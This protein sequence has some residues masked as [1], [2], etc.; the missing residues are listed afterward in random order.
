MFAYYYLGNISCLKIFPNTLKL[1]RIFHKA[2][3]FCILCTFVSA[4]HPKMMAYARRASR[5]RY[6]ALGN[7]HSAFNHLFC[8]L[9]SIVFYERFRRVYDQCTGVFFL[10]KY[11]ENPSS[12]RHTYIKFCV[13]L[14]YKI[15]VGFANNLGLESFFLQAV[16]DFTEYKCVVSFAIWRIFHGSAYCCN[17]ICFHFSLM[18][19]SAFATSSI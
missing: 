5:F 13:G 6:F 16:T 1:L 11:V 12:P 8:Y 2:N 15:D 17:P 3:V 10:F 19:C 9:Y 18:N 4:F 7:G 14:F